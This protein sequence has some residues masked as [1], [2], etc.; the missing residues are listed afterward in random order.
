VSRIAGAQSILTISLDDFALYVAWIHNEQG[1]LQGPEAKEMLASARQTSVF[2]RN[3]FRKDIPVAVTGRAFE[4][5]ALHAL[6]R[7]E[8]QPT[9][10]ARFDG[11]RVVF[12][13]APAADDVATSDMTALQLQR[14]TVSEMIRSVDA[15]ANAQAAAAVV[16]FVHP[17]PTPPP[18][19][20][21][22][23]AHKIN[24]AGSHMKKQKPSQRVLVEVNKK[25][26]LQQTSQLQ[27]QWPVE[28]AVIKEEEE[29]EQG[30]SDADSEMVDEEQA[31]LP[32]QSQQQQ[33]AQPP[34]PQE[35][36][37]VH[38]L[39]PFLPVFP[40]H[41][42]EESLADG[43]AD[44]EFSGEEAEVQLPQPLQQAV[45]APVEAADA[46]QSQWWPVWGA[47]AVISG[48]SF[49]STG[50]GADDADADADAD[51]TTDEHLPN[52][53]LPD[54]FIEDC[55]LT[56]HPPSD[57][58][59]FASGAFAFESVDCPSSPL[60]SLLP[61]LTLL[62]ASHSTSI[63]SLELEQLAPSHTDAVDLELD[64]TVNGFL[65]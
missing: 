50:T 14:H 29:E 51:G 54:Q 27:I 61:A 55:S 58:D 40:S 2:G 8:V 6:I 10:A 11:K 41:D 16:E 19:K 15:P 28:E 20:V 31:E 24:G 26:P 32:Q 25:Q 36:P 13:S 49:P 57:A 64:A 9:I 47:P 33:Q 48:E 5:A 44:V 12:V 4:Q 7:P 23:K 34:Q 43:E 38:W 22:I 59:L 65:A 1:K 46:A 17:L 53:L 52:S 45:D 37:T 18:T 35:Q 21:A 3:R 30:S 56:C 42:E 63:S 60:P 62:S 39:P